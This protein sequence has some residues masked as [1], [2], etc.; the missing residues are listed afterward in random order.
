MSYRYRDV[1][2]YATG[3]DFL[4]DV[5]FFDAKSDIKT[6]AINPQFIIHEELLGKQNTLTFGYDY[7]NAEKDIDN[8]SSY[9]DEYT[10]AEL[11]KENYGFYIHN[12]LMILEDLGLSA[13]YRYDRAEYESDT[14]SSSTLRKTFDEEL[15][16]AGINYRLNSRSN[17]YASFSR[18]FRYPVMDEMFDYQFSNVYGLSPQKSKDF[19]IGIRYF[20]TDT[21]RLSISLFKVDTEDEILYDPNSLDPIS[22]WPGSNINLD[23]DTEREGVEL[24]LKNSF[25]WGTA[26]IAYTYTKAKIDGGMYDNSDFPGVPK[27]Q[28]SATAVIDLWKPFTLA[29]N[30]I[31]IGQRTFISDFDNDFKDQEDYVVVNAKLQYKWKKVTTFIDINNL[32]DKEYDEFGVLG[33]YPVERA[34]YPSPGINFMAGIT[35]DF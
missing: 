30:S 18:S 13:G 3:I 14:S 10:N 2:N 12:D 26:S 35:L 19:E 24:S 1:K 7:S 21:L 20:I 11:E 28:A 17:I 29:I 6:L 16:T 15:F 22:G 33:G 32:F 9:T 27:H 23:G 4:G 34:Y 8:Y 31:Y 25:K 5:W